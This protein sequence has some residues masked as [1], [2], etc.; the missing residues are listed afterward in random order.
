MAIGDDA[1]AAFV[2]SYTSLTLEQPAEAITEY[3]LK[4][5]F[6]L[7]LRQAPVLL[8][9]T[10]TYLTGNTALTEG[11]DFFTAERGILYAVP[12][13]VWDGK[14]GTWKVEYTPGWGADA[15][16]DDLQGAVDAIAGLELP[17]AAYREE[18]IGDYRYVLSALQ[19]RGRIDILTTL[20]LYKRLVT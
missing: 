19:G 15:M 3:H 7:I 2:E 1:A 14:R 4:M 10:V 11:E 18:Q 6:P 8:T 9:P 17:E 12:S 16:P 5:T 20:D 13:S